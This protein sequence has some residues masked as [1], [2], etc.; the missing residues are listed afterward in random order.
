MAPEIRGAK[1]ARAQIWS[2]RGRGVL[3]TSTLIACL[4][5]KRSIEAND[6]VDIDG[7]YSRTAQNAAEQTNVVGHHD[8]LYRDVRI[9]AR[10]LLDL[11]AHRGHVVAVD[12]CRRCVV[13]AAP[14]RCGV[15]PYEGDGRSAI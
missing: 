9:G 5:Y 6:A 3:S 1:Q 14:E 10:E 2:C 13:C 12:R 8:I 15:T 11:H 7:V 4:P